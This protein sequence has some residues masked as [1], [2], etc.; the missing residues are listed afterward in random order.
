ML[1]Y[2]QSI[3]KMIMANWLNSDHVIIDTETTGLMASDEIIE[4]TIINM[5]GEILLNTLVKPSRPIPPEVTKINNITNEMVADAP[6]WCDVFPAALKIIRKHKWLAWNSSFDA[7][8]MVQTCLQTG[9]FDDLKPHLIT[10]IIM[11]IETR[12]IDAKAVY[13][14]WYGEFDEKRKNFK[15]QSLA[16]AAARHGIPTAGAHRALA[17]CLMILGVLKQVCQPEV[18]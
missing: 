12:H 4:I 18:A 10:S 8:L 17:D 3:F 9:F 2:H 13:D 15:R 11:A 1:T 14:Q 16:T 5:R 7:R 6:A